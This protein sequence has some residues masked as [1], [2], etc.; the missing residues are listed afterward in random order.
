MVLTGGIGSGK[1]IVAKFMSILGLPVFDAD[2]EAKVLLETDEVR[3]AVTAVFGEAAYNGDFPNKVYLARKIF[4]DPV[5]REK[6]NAIVHPAVAGTF[7]TWRNGQNG[8]LYVVK[9][10]AIAIEAGIHRDADAVI[11]VTAPK[12][13]RIKRVMER[14]KIMKGEVEKRMQAQWTDEEK[15]PFASH[16]IHNDGNRAVIPQIL[17]IHNELVSLAR[18]ENSNFEKK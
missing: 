7:E 16:V 13:V 5:L 12:E 9:E 14:N 2:I 17:K 8:N 6:L 11:L 3:N 10:A 1:S 18:N 4:D 15:L